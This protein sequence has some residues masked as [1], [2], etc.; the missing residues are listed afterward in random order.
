MRAGI[1]FSANV[2]AGRDA[3]VAAML[4]EFSYR[5]VISG[6]YG[7]VTQAFRR[8]EPAWAVALTTM[9]VLPAMNHSIE[10]LVHWTR[11][12][13]KLKASIIASISFTVVSTLFNLYAMRRGFM[14][15]DED[16]KSLWQDLRAMP[17][18]VVGFVAAVPLAIWRQLHL[19]RD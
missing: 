13:E 9:I 8:A 11:G 15:V 16:R 4:T 1:F 18:I 14:V 3:A 12:T 10:F 19:E 5:V 17:A 6:F 2:S 7:S